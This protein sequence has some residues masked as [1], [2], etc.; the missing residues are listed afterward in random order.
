MPVI[1]VNDQLFSLRP[2][3]TRLGSG[4]DADLRLGGAAVVGVQA[5]VELLNGS[6]PD[7]GNAASPSRTRAV[8]WRADG[9]APIRINGISL[10]VEPVPLFHGD[11]VEIAGQELFYSDESTAG[12]PT[13]I[14]TEAIGGSVPKAV[15]DESRI[16][17]SSGGRLVSLVDGKEYA[18]PTRGIKIGREAGAD[19]VVAQSDV[20]RI[21]AEIV[22]VSSG[23][24]LRD[25]STNGML[26]N[27]ARAEKA[28]LLGR[29]DVIRIGGEE[30]RFT[31]DSPGTA[32][33]PEPA[34]AQ[35]RAPRVSGE[36]VSS[37]S[38]RAILAVLEV[39]AGSARGPAHDLTMPLVHIGSGDRND[40]IIDDDSVAESHAKLQLR[41]DGWYVVDMRS[42]NG[43]YVNGA[44]VDREKKLHGSPVIRFGSV[45]A[46]FRPRDLV[47]E[48]RQGGPAERPQLYNT[49]ATVMPAVPSTP[50]GRAQPPVPEPRKTQTWVWA[51]AILAL[52]AAVAFFVF[53]S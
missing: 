17:G 3:Q 18:I 39:A 8:I 53:K 21:H 44:R 16:T 43:T 12:A 33:A 47:S 50:A 6:D 29:G 7:E 37:G 28:Q 23:Y 26:I 36:A 15:R 30:F 19:V 34:V 4:S 25:R 38:R 10:G 11:K 32:A 52:I 49:L 40:V 35:P 14:S 42:P 27:G 13:P 51:S 5:V 9:V 2:G 45:T 46:I 20:S 1:R 48:G 31:A 41:N 24:E 22:P